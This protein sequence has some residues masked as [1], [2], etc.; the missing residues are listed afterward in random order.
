MVPAFL[1]LT[2]PRRHLMI[3]F[4]TLIALGLVST[5]AITAPAFATTTAPATKPAAASHAVPKAAAKPHVATFAKPAAAPHVAAAKPAAAAHVAVA[6][7]AAPHAVAAAR[8]ATAAKPSIFARA[9]APAAR[10]ATRISSNHANGRMVTTRTSTGK[11]VTY[12][13]S[14]AG[15]QTKQA[16]KG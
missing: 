16:C 7:P 11:T 1:D 12:N 10:P 9:A 4:H 8:P 5:M 6:K 2:N 15:N 13:C 3:K 14:L